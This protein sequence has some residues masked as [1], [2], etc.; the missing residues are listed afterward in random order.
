MKKNFILSMAVM[1]GLAL[2]ATSCNCTPSAHLSNDIDS[3][4]Y[5]FGVFQ[6]NQL[7][8]VADSNTLIPDE[9]VD[10]DEFLAGF[11]TAVRRDSSNLKMTPQE[12]QQYLDKYFR[13]I[14]Q[15]MQEEA[16]A[17][18]KEEK[19]KGAEFMAKNATVEGVVTTESGLQIQTITEGKGKQP[20]AGDKVMVNY[21]GKLIDGTVFDENDSIEFNTNGVVMGFKEG[22][23][24]M[25]EGGKA[26][27]TMPSDLGYGDRGAGA[28]IP[29][30]ATLQFEVELLKVTPSNPK[31]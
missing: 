13:A 22:L 18:A 16:L 28:D 29:G 1:A 14:Q 30:G 12:A 25:K 27:I 17:K 15:K 23:L 8:A 10:F 21:V 4:A 20:K 24:S 31:K 19:A 2:S 11:L 7:A 9:Q 3:V 5:A 6:G 26:I